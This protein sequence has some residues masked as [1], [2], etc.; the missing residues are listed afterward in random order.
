MEGAG[1]EAQARAIKEGWTAPQLYAAIRAKRSPKDRS[2]GR[3]MQKPATPE[4]GLQQLTAEAAMWI[5]RC[6][7]VTSEIKRGKPRKAGAGL[8]RRAEEALDVLVKVE[9]AAHEAA[10]DL[11]KLLL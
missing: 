5:R 2:H 4:V 3:P 8:Q 6:E 10:R 1:E 11:Q 9:K 7:V